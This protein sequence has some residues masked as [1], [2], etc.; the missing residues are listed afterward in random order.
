M[1]YSNEASLDN[2]ICG[3][4]TAINTIGDAFISWTNRDPSTS[5]EGINLHRTFSV[6]AGAGTYYLNCQIF[7][8]GG[9]LQRIVMTAEYHS[10]WRGD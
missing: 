2:L 4:D 8:G 3:I 5:N 6:G 1:T 9:V 10:T 7:G